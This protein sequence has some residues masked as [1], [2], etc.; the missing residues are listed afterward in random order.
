MDGGVQFGGR[1]GVVDPARTAGAGRY[2]GGG[3][4]NLRGA[5]AP[6][7]GRVLHGLHAALFDDV[8]TT[9]ATAAEC[10]RVLRAA[11]AARISLWA[12]ARAP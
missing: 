8:V 2:A 6:G 11:G 4:A 9:G 1:P 5:F 12:V 3:R 7:P 10:A